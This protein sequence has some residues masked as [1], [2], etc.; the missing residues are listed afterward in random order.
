MGNAGSFY[1]FAA[2]RRDFHTVVVGNPFGDDDAAFG[3]RVTAILNERNTQQST[4]FTTEPGPSAR[5]QY[6]LVLLF[7]PAKRLTPNGLCRDTV[8]AS[9]RPANAQAITVQAAFC[10][11][12]KATVSIRGNLSGGDDPARFEQ[13]V[14]QMQWLLLSPNF[15]RLRRVDA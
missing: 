11:G 15:A 7:N 1:G 13:F 10:D 6:K 2:G 14:A 8:A 12:E 5:L 3:Q 9:V 4:N